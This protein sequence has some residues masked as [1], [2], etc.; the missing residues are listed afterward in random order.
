M[1]SAGK[2]KISNVLQTITILPLLLFGLIILGVGTHWF[3]KSMY[4]EVEIELSNVSA[5]LVTM[6]D[7]LYPGHYRLENETSLQLYKGDHDLT[8]DYALI[9]RIKEDTGMEIT[10]FY[11]DTRILTTITDKNGMRI[12]GT[13]APSEAAKEVLANG[14]PKFYKKTRINGSNYFSYYIPLRN[15]DNAVV[16]MLFVGKDKTVKVTMTF[17]IVQGDA[18]DAGKNLRIADEKLYE[19]KAGGRNRIVA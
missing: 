16:G 11:Q 10:L 2:R 18:E 14:N 17:G 12:I 4:F 9:D 5:N 6:Y 1:K 19:G 8:G 13:A 15:Q 3:T 7:L